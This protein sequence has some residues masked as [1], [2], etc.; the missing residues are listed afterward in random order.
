MANYFTTLCKHVPTILT[1]F[2]QLCNT[3]STICK[4]SCRHSTKNRS[5]RNFKLLAIVKFACYLHH[6]NPFLQPYNMIILQ[7]PTFCNF[8]I[9]INFARFQHVSSCLLHVNPGSLKTANLKGQTFHKFDVE[10]FKI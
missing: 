7:S 2:Q 5:N 4:V 3:F 9:F 6:S 1:V 8:P 10:I